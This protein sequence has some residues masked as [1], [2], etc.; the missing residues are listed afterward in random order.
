M[1]RADCFQNLPGMSS[2]LSWGPVLFLGARLH[3]PGLLALPFLQEMDQ[4][5]RL[6][7]CVDLLAAQ[8][9]LGGSEASPL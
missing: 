5:L 7:S 8:G 3:G 9:N 6:G 2:L 4:G 1:P